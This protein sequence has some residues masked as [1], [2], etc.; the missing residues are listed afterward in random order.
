MV[1]PIP[2]EPPVRRKSIA[3]IGNPNSGKSTLFNAL[4]GLNAQTGNFPGTTVEGKHARIRVSGVSIEL[5]DLPGA[6]S[7]QAATPDEQVA[8]DY[9]LGC[10]EGREPPDALVVTVD[11]SNMERNLFLASQVLELGM[12]TVIALTMGDIAERHGMHVDPAKLATELGCPVVAV[13]AK[14][15]VGISEIKEAMAGLIR[16]P[17]PPP[18]KDCVGP[19]AC[20][21]CTSCAFNSRFNWTEDV[22]SRVIT[23]ESRTTRE[24]TDRLDAILTHPKLGLLVFMTVML[25]IF[26][27]IFRV[28][29]IPMELIDGLFGSVGGWIEGLLPAGDFRNLLVQGVI[30]G[31]GGM[32]VFLPQIC[33]LFFFLALLEDTGY[34]ARAAFVMDRL[35]RRVGLPGTA[36]VPMVSAHACAIPAIMAT[37]IIGDPRDRLLTIL[38]LPLMT[39]SARI[40]VYAMV[41]ALL[42]PNDHLK[43]AF[44]FCGAIP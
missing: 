13:N 1:H 21:S 18:R 16:D 25:T 38:V 35:M 34:M 29:Q 36:F 2:L 23:G 27:L 28:A 40:P 44:V 31:V 8:S 24:R 9:L 32:L 3:L 10:I 43:A 26:Y 37:R 6:Y 11:A 22:T 7:L 15:N 20:D 30:G 12:P 39:C 5:I 4:T 33:I 17:E 14:N 42:F 19:Q 41:T